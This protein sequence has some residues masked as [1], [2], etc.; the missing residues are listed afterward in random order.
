MNEKRKEHRLHAVVPVRIVSGRQKEVIGQTGNISRL[1]TYAEVDTE[2]KTG[3]KLEVFLQLPAYSED[4]SRCGE[5][6]CRG[7]VFRAQPVRESDRGMLYGIGIFF[8]DF[9]T[10]QDKERLSR[11]VDYLQQAEA[12]GV[13]QALRRRKEQAAAG[14]QQ[15]RSPPVPKEEREF[16]TKVLRS[17]ADLSG[18]LDE[19]KRLLKTDRRV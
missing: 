7:T 17:L 13:R 2:I 18:S 8:T 5:V 11:Y 19:I 3:E 12:G 1:G 14:R 6:S 16:R 15:R 9:G 10:P 4:P